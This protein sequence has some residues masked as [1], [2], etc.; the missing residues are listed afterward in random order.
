MMMTLTEKAISNFRDGLNC[1]QAVLTA[2]AGELKIDDHTALSVSCGFGGG[3]G[4]LQET[5]GAATG[6]FMVMGIYNSSKYSE[7]KDR[8]DK[9]YAM[10]REFSNR[11][12]ERHGTLKCRELMNCD[13]NTPEGQQYVKDSNLH[14]TVCEKCIADSIRIIGEIMH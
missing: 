14:E 1:A 2:Y 5:C 4:R 8:K 7:N 13:L 11:F 10:V 9:T 3:M 6:S 12:V